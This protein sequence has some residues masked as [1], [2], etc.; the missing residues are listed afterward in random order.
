[1][2]LGTVNEMLKQNLLLNP[3][4]FALHVR[5]IFENCMT[6]NLDEAPIHQTARTLLTKFNELYDNMIATWMSQVA[7]TKEEPMET[8]PQEQTT[9]TAAELE[10]KQECEALSKTIDELKTD[11]SGLRNQI[12]ELKK[13]QRKPNSIKRVRLSRPKPP[14]SYK[15]KEELCKKISTLSPED[16]PGLLPIIQ[17]TQQNSGND[18]GEFEIMV[19]ALDDWTLHNVLAYVNDKLRQQK[20]TK[21]PPSSGRR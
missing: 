18:D 7:T 6:F 3:P 13:T 2:D 9:E 15:Q 5:L 8:E 12:N 16:L 20:R 11:V 1:M 10:M 19:D 17:E 4:H 21:K 14:L